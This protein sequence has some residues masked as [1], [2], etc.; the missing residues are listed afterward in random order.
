MP[1]SSIAGASLRVDAARLGRRID[2]LGRI[3]AIDGTTG[4]ARLALTDED[5]AGRDLVLAWMRELGLEISIDGIGNVVATMPH[6]SDRAPVMTGSHIDTVATGGRYDGNLGVLGGLEVIETVLASGRELE[7]PLAVGWFTDEEGARFPPD[8]LGSLVYVGGLPLES[9]LEITDADG[10]AVGDE[11]DRIG[12]RGTAPIPGRVPHAFVELHIEQGPVLE[13][14]GITIGAV[15]GVQGISWTELTIAGRSAHAGTTPMR[16]RRDPGIVAARTN[17]FVRELAERF[18][19][20]Q[21]ATCGVVTH[22]PNLVNVV[23]SQVVMT[24]DLRNADEA[25]LQ[26]A[27]AEFRA[28]VDDA[29]EAEG[30]TVASRALARFEPVEFDERV[31]GVV[32]AT[33]AD[34]GHAVR[35][36]PS[37]AGHDAQMF[38][39]V[40]PTAMIFTPSVDGISHNVDEFTHP[41][42]LVAGADTLLQTMIR[43]TEIEWGDVE[44]DEHASGGDGR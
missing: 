40:C 21:V 32:E 19:G 9:A 27:E 12:Y 30:C 20:A 38:A 25:I 8:M 14:E 5:R 23:P 15:N 22:R 35:R 29:A 41:D 7:R 11:L 3:G 43:L 39:R 34:L 37:G 1:Q 44:R 36:M 33:A 16:L 24:V 31:I 4:C 17:V 18:G 6:P 28:F 26:Q 13:D 2:E 42:D 10:I